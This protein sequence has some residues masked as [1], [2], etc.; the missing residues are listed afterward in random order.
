EADSINEDGTNNWGDDVDKLVEDGVVFR[1]DTIEELAEKIG[2]DPE[3][4]KETHDT[5]NRYAEAGTDEEF[6]RTLF[7]TPIKEGPFYA[8]PRVPTVHHTMGGLEIDLETHVL[9]E[10]GTK[11]TG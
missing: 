6:G 7:G 3:V 5:F 8:S 2:V 11:S 1:A 10:E 9:D 4:L